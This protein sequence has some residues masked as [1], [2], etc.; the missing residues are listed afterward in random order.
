MKSINPTTEQVIAEY[1]DHSPA[2]VEQL[3]EQAERAFTQW[4]TKSFEERGDLLRRVGELLLEQKPDLS[5]LMTREMGKT[6]A[7]AE[8]E[9]EK[10]ASACDYFA[11]HAHRL[12]AIEEVPTDATRSYVRFDPLGP[13]LAIMPWNFP[14]WQVFRFAAPSLMAGNVAVLK[15]AWNV[16]GCG[17]AIERIFREA[18]FP[19]G[20]F[21]NLLL[22]NQAAEA[23][24]AHPRIRAVTLT[25]SERAGKAVGSAAGRVLKKSVLELGGSDPFIVCPDVDIPATASA[26]AAARCINAGQSCIAAKRFLVHESI[27][28]RFERAFADRMSSLKLGDPLD[29]NT[30]IGPLARAD[31][32]DSLDNQVKKT[33]AA[34]ARL[35]CG[36]KKPPMRGFFYPPTV[37]ADVR[38]GMIAFDEETFGPVAAVT[39]V[40]NMDEA[41]ELANRSRFGLGAT[42]WTK[43]IALAERLA[44]QIE[45]GSVFI[46]GAVKSDSRLPFGGIKN[47]G[48]GRELAEVGIREFVNIKTVWIK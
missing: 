46:N 42:I 36:G 21:T 11:N 23:L 38:P 29:R 34:G 39:R 45:S 6:I 26:A 17:L 31:L 18:G 35:L 13:I 27:A 8:A 30:E 2:Q 3:L 16:P 20:V 14:F 32:R 1:P 47:S 9:I 43:D 37:L 28:D 19:P 10:C 4:R 7:G 41:V 12:L 22:D 33:L 48:Y 5:T 44:A 25:G 40:K 24:I 15:H